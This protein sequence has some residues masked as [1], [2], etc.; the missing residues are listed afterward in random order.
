MDRLKALLKKLGATDEQVAE[1]EGLVTEHT[2]SAV[3]A[4]VAG[5]KKKNKEL[6]EKYK[7]P[8]DDARNKLIALEQERDELKADLAR[9]QKDS[10]AAKAKLAKAEKERDD[11]VAAAKKTVADLL[12][13]GGLTAAFAGKV[14]DAHLTAVKLL[15]AGKF[16][17][18]YDADGKPK[19]LATV[20]SA[21]GKEKKLT[22]AEFASEWLG[23]AEGREWA[24]A[25]R[26][27]G[28]GAGG[29][30]TGGDAPGKKWAEMSYQEQIKLYKANPVLANQ[31]MG[32]TV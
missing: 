19:A 18:E 24:L 26:N 27:V 15:H 25:G 2:Q 14:K 12:V 30:G 17:V 31:M 13:D 9:I 28:G 6:L 8:D 4:E 3:D 10:D 32:E 23:S 16:V 5:L 22:P 20:K 1:A 21:D 11:Q 29:S 7:N